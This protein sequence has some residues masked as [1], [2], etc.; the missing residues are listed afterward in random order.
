M[1]GADVVLAAGV[2]GEGGAALSLA[3][4]AT[5]TLPA[6]LEV[7]TLRVDGTQEGGTLVNFRPASRG[8][9]YLTN[10]D[11]H[12]IPVAVQNLQADVLSSWS[13]YVDGVLYPRRR[14]MVE[15]GA[16]KAYSGLAMTIR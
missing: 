2:A 9:L 10:G 16:L 8:A 4:G 11:I 1:D 15:N 6:E 5:L 13:V 12:D 14:L 7:S 3:H